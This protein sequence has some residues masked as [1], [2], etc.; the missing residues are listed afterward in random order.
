MKNL[1]VIKSNIDMT[2]GYSDDEQKRNSST[3]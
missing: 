3:R 2:L 1:N